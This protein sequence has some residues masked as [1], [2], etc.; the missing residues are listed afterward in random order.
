MNRL[1]LR[2]N[3]SRS[4]TTSDVRP[5]AARLV[6]PPSL[7]WSGSRRQVSAVSCY[8]NLRRNLAKTVSRVF[9]W[10]A[11][12]KH[13]QGRLTW[14]SLLSWNFAAAVLS[15]AVPSWRSFRGRVSECGGRSCRCLESAGK[16]WPASEGPS[17]LSLQRTNLH[18]PQNSC[19]KVCI[20]KNINGDDISTSI[21]G[22]F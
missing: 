10:K 4:K 16:T 6:P 2:V 14:I 8:W 19:L 5:T 9:W 17:S 7:S 12:P 11:P 18:L 3:N 15:T 20:I 1:R 13:S 22:S 21:K